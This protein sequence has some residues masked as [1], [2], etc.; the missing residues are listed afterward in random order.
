MSA[1]SIIPKETVIAHGKCGCCKKTVEIKA[2]KNGNAYYFCPWSNDEG[3]NCSHHERWG[4]A[5]SRKL[6]QA[7]LAGAKPAAPPVRKPVEA[8]EAAPANDDTPPKPAQ[9]PENPGKGTYLEYV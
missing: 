5:Y 7:Y 2:N 8:V 3:E 4:R 1:R 9:T 6:R